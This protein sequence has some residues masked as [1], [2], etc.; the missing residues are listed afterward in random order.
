MTNATTELVKGG[1]GLSDE[2]PAESS[3]LATA[4]SGEVTVNADMLQSMGFITPLATPEQLRAAFGYQQQMMAAILDERD[5]IYV[6][7]WDEGSKR[8][9]R[10]ESLRSTAKQI[11][12]KV[13]KLNG[14][15][16]AKPKKSGIVKLAR[17]LG[18]TATRKRCEGLPDDPKATYSYVEY[19]AFHERTGKRETGVGWCDNT[20]RGGRISKHDIISTAD[21]RAYNRAVLRLAGFGDV[22][23][24]EI[25]AGASFGSADE[26][27]EPPKPAAT[28]EMD[29]LPDEADDDVLAAASTWAEAVARRAADNDGKYWA[30]DAKQDTREARE[31]RAKAR[32]GNLRAAKQLGTKGLYW[33]GTASDGIGYDTFTVYEPPTMPA[34]IE[35]AWE[36]ADKAKD[37]VEAKIGKKR[38][39]KGWNLSGKGSDKDDEGMPPDIAE[40]IEQTTKAT[41]IPSPAPN[42]DPITL[43]Q[44]KK[45]S[46]LLKACFAEKA[47]AVQPAEK[48]AMIQWLKSSAHVVKTTEIHANQYEPIMRALKALKKEKKSDG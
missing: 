25:V 15:M 27:V 8:K 10:I 18:I 46:E 44:A 39:D 47:N 12:D 26:F 16:S 33:K 28:K 6:V 14:D 31:L 30:P 3:A 45:V 35:A 1:I 36:A 23:A 21:T 22:S 38:G 11:F 32:R 4:E 37:E 43:G 9:Q 34:D 5:Y 41:G 24:D 48:E 20:E 7:S 40:N 13:E 17:G 42:A 19:E 29:P 2:I